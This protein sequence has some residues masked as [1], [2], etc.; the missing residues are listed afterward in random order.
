MEGIDL[1]SIEPGTKKDGWFPIGLGDSIRL[2]FSGVRGRES[3]MR[4]LVIGAQHGD[5][6]FGILGAAKIINRIDPEKLKGEVWALPCIN[7]LAYSTGSHKSIYDQQDMNRVH[8]G[9]PRGS[10]TE[11]I[12]HFLHTHFLP[13]VDLVIDLHGGSSDLGDILSGFG[14]WVEG[15][16]SDEYSCTMREL[17]EALGLEYLVVPGEEEAPGLLSGNS[18]RFKMGLI[19]IEAGS[20]RTPS[21]INGIEMANFVLRGLSHLDM[22][23]SDGVPRMDRKAKYVRIISQR[24]STEG[25]FT[26][27]VELGD[28][29]K[30]GDEIGSI[31]DFFGNE[32]VRFQAVQPGVILVLRT[33]VRT[34]PGMYLYGV[35]VLAEQ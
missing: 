13:K 34:L 18:D 28:H 33:G 2:P 3:G 15:K 21:H 35:G 24:A 14:H 5:E 20:S 7:P 23:P 1:L 32:L 17:C 25:L 9:N 8:P 22:I 16:E 11:Q 29:V 10:Y 19:G 31:V 12:V 4:V 6:S 30:V 27:S 26:S